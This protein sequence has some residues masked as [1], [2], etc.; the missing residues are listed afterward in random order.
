MDP[1]Y[2]PNNADIIRAP[3]NLCNVKE[4]PLSLQDVNATLIEVPHGKLGRLV[5]QF[6]RVDACLMT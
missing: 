2:R 1:T 5:H 3:E 4:T 6:D